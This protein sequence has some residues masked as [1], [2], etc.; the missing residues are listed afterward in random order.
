MM[1]L[2]KQDD[3]KACSD[4]PRKSGIEIAD[5]RAKH[6]RINDLRDN[7]PFI[8]NCGFNDT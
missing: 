7:Y 8:I 1:R 4:C 3:K 6:K 5:L 2:L